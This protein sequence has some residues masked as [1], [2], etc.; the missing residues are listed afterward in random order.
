MPTHHVPASNGP[1]VAKE[2]CE[3]KV[4]FG[5]N[6]RRVPHLLH[7]NKTPHRN[8]VQYHV[9]DPSEMEFRQL[10]TVECP[11]GMWVSSYYPT[12]KNGV[13][14]NLEPRGSFWAALT[15][16]NFAR[17][18]ERHHPRPP[19]PTSPSRISPR[20]DGTI[21]TPQYLLDAT[22]LVFIHTM[23]QYFPQSNLLDER[24]RFRRTFRDLLRRNLTTMS[25]SICWYLQMGASVVK[26]GRGIHL[27]EWK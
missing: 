21:P 6:W 15:V 17:C 2:H 14:V 11:E 7:A 18:P 13:D 24:Q 4:V 8:L 20:I 27:R 22:V 12:S 1:K 19:H 3:N 16:G 23:N 5:G 10:Q 26:E 9:M 25:I